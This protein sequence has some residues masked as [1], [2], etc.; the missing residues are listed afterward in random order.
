MDHACGCEILT[1]PYRREAIRTAC[2]M[3]EADDV[4]L[5]A[6]KGHE[7]AQEINGVVFPFS[8]AAEVVK[9]GFS[10]AGSAAE[11]TRRPLL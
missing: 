10:A 3:A 5:I 1:E 7:A 11:A 2:A 9:N 8:D 4:I 6:G